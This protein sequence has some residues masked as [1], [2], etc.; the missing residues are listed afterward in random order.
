MTSASRAE[1][2]RQAHAAIDAATRELDG[3]AIAGEEWQRRVSDALA[4]AYLRDDDPRWQ[5]GFDGDARLWREARELVLDAVPAN[6]SL[7]DVGCATGHLMES[8]EQWARERGVVIEA[9]GLE[10]SPALAE[11]GRRRLPLY[12]A[13]IYTGNVS[14]WRPPR[15][16]TYVR[17]GLEYVPAA[18]R[19]SLV[20]RVLRDLVEPG[21][22]VIVG[23]VN[24]SDVPATCDAFTAA[25]IPDAGVESST[26]HN[27]KTR[28]VVWAVADPA[29]RDHS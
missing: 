12:E 10:L 27:G 15:R 29:S 13:R 23:P 20:T 11:E 22:R 21:G 7:L 3:G 26:D 25:G 2:K 8:L 17:T 18:E 28:Y 1:A 6:G 16:F 14:T 4:A 5:S 19:A 24:E 9:H